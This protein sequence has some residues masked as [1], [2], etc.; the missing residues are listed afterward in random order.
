MDVL[1]VAQAMPQIRENCG[2]CTVTLEGFGP[3]L[4]GVCHFVLSTEGKMPPAD[5][6]ESIRLL[7][8]VL[9]TLLQV[10]MPFVAT[11]DFQSDPP[12]PI[13]AHLS[14]FFEK[15]RERL[16]SRQKAI[17]L[18]IKENIFSAVGTGLLLYWFKAS[19]PWCPSLIC[20]A[21]DSSQEFF[22]WVA[23]DG[24]ASTQNVSAFVSVAEVLEATDGHA[25]RSILASLRPL[26][27]R[28]CSIDHMVPQLA[29]A[30]PTLHSLPNGD[31]RVIQSPPRDVIVADG[32]AN[33]M[34][35]G[36][37]SSSS[38]PDLG[39]VALKFRCSKSRLAQ[40]QGSHF[41]IGELLID[42]EKESDSRFN[43]RQQLGGP[44]D[45]CCWGVLCAVDAFVEKIVAKM[46]YPSMQNMRA[47]SAE[48]L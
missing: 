19:F 31:V 28:P 3:A 12:E 23:A 16:R 15:H 40:L 26:M 43:R 17:A 18:L 20:H 45:C 8:A 9:D 34:G 36:S 14:R 5:L 22:R 13:T 44:V 48:R 27:K 39:A 41:H 21:N 32:S 35:R 7:T 33:R 11:L 47:R 37:P 38:K 30:A 1:A 6:G 42:A 2:H 25:S 29:G 4:P 46:V 24:N 10:S